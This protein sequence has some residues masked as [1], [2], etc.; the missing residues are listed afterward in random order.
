[1]TETKQHTG[2]AAA[3]VPSVPLLEMRDITK[4]FPGVVA[5]SHVNLTIRQGEIHL[6]LGENGAGKSTMIKTIIG[7]NKPEGGEMR[8]MG[9]PVKLRSLE[10]AYN[11]GIAVIYQELSNIPCLSVVE[12]MYLGCEK[13]KAGLINWKEQRRSAKKALARVGLTDIDVDMPMEK[14][15][16]GQ[17]QLVEIARAVDRNAK[18]LIMDE[19]TSSLSRKEIDFLLDLMLDLN[20]QG[21]A[22][23]FITHKLDEAKKVGHM[24]TVLKNGQNS[25]TSIP[26]A[27]VTEDQ[28]IKLMVGRSLEEKFPKRS[29][30]IGEEVFRCENLCAEKFDNISFNVKKGELLGVFGLVGAGRTETMRAIFGADPL[31]DGRLYLNGQQIT[32]KNPRDSIKKGIVLITEN[33]KEEGLVLIHNVIENGTLVTM[34]QFRNQFGLVSNKKRREMVTQYGNELNLR[35]MQ[36]DKASVNFSGGNQQKIVIMKWLLSGAKVFIFDEPTKGVD[37]GAKVEIYTIM[38]RLLEQGASIIMVSSEMEEILGMSDRVMVMYEG[39]Q[40]GVVANDGAV[41]Q[42]EILTLATGGNIG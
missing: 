17:R 9:Q 11:L 23:L 37:V 13:Q 7:I 6:L 32:V 38:N 26:V 41:G 31:A 10:D 36:P 16:M 18:L 1:M 12:N 25:G 28:I 15:G 39:K 4:M 2:A 19:P 34:K 24:V 3:A 22:I 33:R 27:D 20:R 29:V 14:L 35:P 21:V 42:E 30:P 8:W 40:T 5:L